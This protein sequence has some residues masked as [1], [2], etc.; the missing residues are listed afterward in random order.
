MNRISRVPTKE[1]VVEMD[2]S[3]NGLNG[4]LWPENGT[5]CG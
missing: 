3:S 4:V 1:K 5:Q 2:S